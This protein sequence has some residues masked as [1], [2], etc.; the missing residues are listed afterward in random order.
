[1]LYVLDQKG[2]PQIADLKNPDSLITVMEAF[3]DIR[4]RR[5][6]ITENEETEIIT[7]FLMIDHG[8]SGEGPVLWET[9][10]LRGGGAHEGYQARYNSLVEAV[11]GHRTAVELAFPEGPPETLWG[12]LPSL[13]PDGTIC[14]ERVEEIVGLSVWERL[15]REEDLV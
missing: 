2:V 13:R 5:V 9:M 6:A 8:F 4:H 15:M 7:S 14:Q 1:V 12:T 11:A 10:I 3:E